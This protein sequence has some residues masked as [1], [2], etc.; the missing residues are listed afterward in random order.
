MDSRD[1][2]SKPVEPLMTRNSTHHPPHH[3][4]GLSPAIAG[5]DY[6]LTPNK[7]F[8]D[9]WKYTFIRIFIFRPSGGSERK[10]GV[11]QKWGGLGGAVLT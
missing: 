2:G 4:R 3:G 10:R 8:V 6:H 1:T 7:F 9:F 5:G 11:W